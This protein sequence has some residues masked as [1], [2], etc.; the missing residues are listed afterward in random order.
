MYAAQHYSEYVKEA[1]VAEENGNYERA[2][3]LYESY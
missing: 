3:P 1:K 2:A